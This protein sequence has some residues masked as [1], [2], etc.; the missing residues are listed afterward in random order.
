MKKM[1]LHKLNS[2]LVLEEV[3]KP[4]CDKSEILVK[5]LFTGINFADSLLIQGKYQEKPLL[6]FSPGMEMSGIIA[7]LGKDVD[8][9]K[10]GQRVIVF[11]NNGGLAE[12]ISVD[13][14][15]VVHIPDKMTLEDAACFVIAYATSFMALNYRAKLKKGER[16][17][18]SGAGG[19][20]GNSAVQIGKIL[21]AYVVALTSGKEKSKLAQKSGADL[22]IDISKTTFS[23]NIQNLKKF[24]V[25]YD[26]VGGKFL[27]EAISFANTEARVLPIGFASGEIPNIPAN[28]YMLKNIDLIGFYWAKYLNYKPEILKKNIIRLFKY[29]INDNLK[30]TVSHIFSLQDANKAIKLLRE[31]KIHGKIFIQIDK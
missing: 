10:L 6:P 19:G 5:I 31:R 23:K 3:N 2:K 12:Y 1:L 4:N 21:G 18:V 25:I 27:R 15:R 24:D 9:F 11:A 16:L 13:P 14:K 28:I 8:G 26:T 20:V 22:I 7:E 29:Y 17:L 30:P